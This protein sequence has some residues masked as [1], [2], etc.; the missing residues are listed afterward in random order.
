[1]LKLSFD[2]SGLVIGE[3]LISSGEMAESGNTELPPVDGR[4]VAYKVKVTKQNA[5]IALTRRFLRD[6]SNLP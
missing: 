1:M 4:V 6:V 2:H 3:L 5:A